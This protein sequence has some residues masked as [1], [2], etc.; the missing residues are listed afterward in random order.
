MD[1][2]TGK[3][4]TG[5]NQGCPAAARA[6]PDELWFGNYFSRQ[7]GQIRRRAGALKHLKAV[8][9]S[10]G[11][12]VTRS[13]IS[14]VQLFVDLSRESG[15]LLAL[16]DVLSPSGERRNPAANSHQQHSCR[17]NSHGHRTSN[18]QARVAARRNAAFRSSRALCRKTE[19]E[20]LTQSVSEVIPR[21]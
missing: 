19:S 6:K 11:E 21:K 2:C 3:P 16:M 12:T 4:Q 14:K 8:R 18:W 17:K 9:R 10:T 13:F 5:S 1:Y 15:I 20:K 7:R